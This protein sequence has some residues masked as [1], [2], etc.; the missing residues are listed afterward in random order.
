M[1]RRQFRSQ[2]PLYPPG[3]RWRALSL[4]GTAC[5]ALP[6]RASQSS[7]IASDWA[8][9]WR[10]QLRGASQ[11][12]CP[13]HSQSHR[14]QWCGWSQTRLASSH[15]C[16]QKDKGGSLANLIACGIVERCIQ[17]PR[18]LATNHSLDQHL[19]FGKGFQAATTMAYSK[20]ESLP[21]LFDTMSRNLHS[22]IPL[23]TSFAETPSSLRF[24]S[25]R[26]VTCDHKIIISMREKDGVDKKRRTH[27]SL[28]NNGMK[29]STR[30]IQSA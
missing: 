15:T 13:C 19:F 7:A 4:Q 22:P 28:P 27:Q 18:H 17:S 3:C 29:G 11:T 20:A 21:A 1:F 16:D 26:S 25:I 10:P 24:P 9:H 14:M 23:T 5:W 30:A 8:R 2:R 6:S 12:A